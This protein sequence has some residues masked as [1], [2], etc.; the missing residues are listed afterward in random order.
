ME[1]LKECG[2]ETQNNFTS[3]MDTA[4]QAAHSTLTQA[5]DDMAQFYNVHRREVPLYVVGDKVWLNGQNITMTQLMKKLDH[6]W[7]SPCSVNK[8]ISQ[9][10]YW[11]K[12]LSSFGHTHPIF[13]V[14]LLKPYNANANAISEHVQCDPPLPV[15]HDQV[16]EYEVN[17]FQIPASSEG[18]FNTWC[19]GKSTA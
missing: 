3:K 5:A 13:L 6:K 11:L 1:L 7:L 10:A 17:T 8:V 9:S 2:L 15:V 12:L 14:T 4:T 16:K 18:N 19:I